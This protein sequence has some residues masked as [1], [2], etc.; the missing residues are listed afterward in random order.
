MG[1]V[2]GRGLGEGR[3]A[4]GSGL[5]GCVGD[6]WAALLGVALAERGT[7]HSKRMET[8]LSPQRPAGDSGLNPC[9]ILEAC[10]E[11]GRSLPCSV[12]LRHP[13]ASMGGRLGLWPAVLM[14]QSRELW[15]VPLFVE[16]LF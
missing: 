13:V 16:F 14:G 1:L 7:S 9:A 12:S 3:A 6:G 15:D 11:R 5:L 2:T 8:V 10:L 4:E